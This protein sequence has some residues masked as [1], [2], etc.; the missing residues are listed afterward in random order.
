MGAVDPSG[1]EVADMY[2]VRC[3]ACLLAS[4]AGGEPDRCKLAAL[5]VMRNRQDL[6]N[7]RSWRGHFRVRYESDNDGQN[8]AWRYES[9]FYNQS[10]MPGKWEG[11]VGSRRHD[12][13]M[14][15]IDDGDAW[16]NLPDAEKRSL[17]TTTRLCMQLLQGDGGDDPTGGAQ[18]FW[19][20]GR[21]LIWM[22]KMDKVGN[23]RKVEIEN[24][25]LDIWVCNRPPNVILLKG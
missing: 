22:K 18:F 3:C 25:D 21:S 14:E 2:E 4:E 15:C 5:W 8:D 17:E 6:V 11:G 16:D 10:N 12:Q 1:M 23:C 24:C 19:S 7:D 9:S 20:Q 13:C